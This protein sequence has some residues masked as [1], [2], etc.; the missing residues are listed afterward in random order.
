MMIRDA[1]YAAVSGRDYGTSQVL[2]VVTFIA[3]LYT[4]ILLAPLVFLRLAESQVGRSLFTALIRLVR[5]SA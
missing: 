3:T 5:C 4:T 1:L 2:L